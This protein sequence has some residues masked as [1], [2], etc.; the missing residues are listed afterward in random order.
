M[1]HAL[2]RHP[3]SLGGAA[4][5][6]ELAITCPAAG[7]LMLSYLVTGPL[8]DLRLPPPA[9]AR[10]ADTLW[11][12]TCFEAFIRAAPGGGYYELNFAPSTEWAAYWLSGYRSGME[13]AHEIDDPAIAV[14][15]SPQ[16][17][18]LQAVIEPDRL[19]RLPRAGWR[20]GVSAL[21]EDV[22]GRKSYWALA[23]P[24]GKPD[25]HHSDCFALAFP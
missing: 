9:T 17:Y 12:H 24:P 5:R 1:R 22:N 23:H 10:R 4:A 3:D 15:S 14:Q 19:S 11:E 16:R 21:I 7:R 18:T 13:A 25:F 6:V 20:L 2:K 8:G